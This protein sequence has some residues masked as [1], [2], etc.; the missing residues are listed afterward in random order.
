M[1]ETERLRIRKFTLDD[2]AWLTEMRLQP[3]VNKYIGGSRL[4]YP[5]AIAKRLLF[6]MDCYEKFGFGQGVMELK[7]TGEII[8]VS[9]IQPLEDTGE[10]EVGY[11]LYPKFWRM[12]FGY[13]CA[14]GWLKYGFEIAGLERIV[15]CADKDNTG[16]WRIMEKCGMKYEGVQEHYG[17]PVVV[18]AV[19]KE[20]FSRSI[21]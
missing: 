3:E 7:E 17:M 6:Y 20:E 14:V 5:E 12:G 10:I 18:Y 13:E 21:K 2:L 19:S 9:G 11:S 16:S 8:G 1:I 4:Q 15:A